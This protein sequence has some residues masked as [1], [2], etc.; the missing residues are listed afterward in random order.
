MAINRAYTQYNWNVNTHRLSEYSNYPTVVIMIMIIDITTVSY[1]ACQLLRQCRWKLFKRVGSKPI[2]HQ[3]NVHLQK[4][5]HVNHPNPMW[6]YFLLDENNKFCQKIYI[7]HWFKVIS[8]A[9]INYKMEHLAIMRSHAF[10]EMENMSTKIHC[11][12]P[13]N[14]VD[15]VFL[16][17][18]A[19]S[20]RTS[21]NVVWKGCK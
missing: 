12:V 17:L 1:V 18:Q 10:E 8:N 7:L 13:S 21:E 4:T 15:K 11:N 19:S 2:V 6:K 5:F 14:L 16:F 3:K 20:K 9:K